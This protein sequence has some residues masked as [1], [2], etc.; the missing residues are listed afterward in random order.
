MKAFITVLL[1]ISWQGL[2]AQTRI[3]GSIKD[4]RKKRITAAS[5]S[6]KDTYDGGTSDSTGMFS[7][8]TTEKGQQ[9]LVVSAVGYKGM[10]QKIEIGSVNTDYHI[11]LKEEI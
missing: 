6:L 11:V 9:T 10:E 4:A 2:L 1:I 3:S 5:V 8:I 7:F